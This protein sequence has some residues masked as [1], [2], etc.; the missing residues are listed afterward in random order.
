MSRGRLLLGQLLLLNVKIEVAVHGRLLGIRLNIV[1][2]VGTCPK[3]PINDLLLFQVIV[4][5]DLFL[6]NVVDLLEVYGASFVSPVL[7]Q[8]IGIL[9]VRV[10]QR[11][12]IY[13]LVR[14]GGRRKT[15]LLKITFIREVVI[16]SVDSLKVGTICRIVV[17]LLQHLILILKIKASFFVVI[18]VVYVLVVQIIV[19]GRC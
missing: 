18:R 5:L 8:P 12:E 17:Q 1:F 3:N 6:A 10:H 11:Y 16:I 9:I 7:A 13:A 14:F 15:S 4:H 19:L 2:S